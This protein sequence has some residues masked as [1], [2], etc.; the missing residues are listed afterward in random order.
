MQEKYD[1]KRIPWHSS[2]STLKPRRMKQQ[3]ELIHVTDRSLTW[4]VPSTSSR[5]DVSQSMNGSIYEL[6]GNIFL[7]SIWDMKEQEEWIHDTIECCLVQHGDCWMLSTIALKLARHKYFILL[8]PAVWTNL[9]IDVNIFSM[10]ALT[11]SRKSKIRSQNGIVTWKKQ[12]IHTCKQD[13]HE[14]ATARQ[15]EHLKHKTKHMSK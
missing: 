15:I 3:Q 13:N 10:F 7:T 1:M 12:M 2:P 11:K 4:M 14:N 8:A 9:L 5:Q 6:E